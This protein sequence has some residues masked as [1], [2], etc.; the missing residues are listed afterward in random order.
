[1]NSL[2]FRQSAWVNI[3]T[4]SS[5]DCGEVEVELRPDPLVRALDAVP[6]HV[7]VGAQPRDLHDGVRL[8]STEEELELRTLARRPA[9]DAVSWA[10][11][12]R[13]PTGSPR[14]RTPGRA[15]RRS[16]TMSDAPAWSILLDGPRRAGED[17]QRRSKPCRRDASP[18]VPVNGQGVTADRVWLNGESTGA[19]EGADHR[20]GCAAR[21]RPMSTP[22]WMSTRFCASNGTAPVHA[23]RARDRRGARPV[24]AAGPEVE[25]ERHDRR[26]PAT[27]TSRSDG[28]R[29]SRA[30]NVSRR[31]ETYP[32]RLTLPGRGTNLRDTLGGSHDARRDP[33]RRL[34]GARRRSRRRREGPRRGSRRRPNATATP[35]VASRRQLRLLVEQRRG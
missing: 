3:T 6:A 4:V 21:R 33:V 34:Q 19:V 10:T 23:R 35:A 5:P 7:P 12:R 16:P 17:M 9:D 22:R 31:S 30:V 11:T 26:S 32:T 2:G 29:C 28:S 13:S 24:R 20:S 1:M 15:G 14:P 8:R 25:V 27:T 18:R